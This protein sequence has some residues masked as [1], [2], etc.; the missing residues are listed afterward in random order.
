M[1]SIARYNSAEE[2]N[3]M[4]CFLIGKGKSVAVVNPG[5]YSYALRISPDLR[6]NTQRDYEYRIDTYMNE[7]R[8]VHG[9]N[10]DPREYTGDKMTTLTHQHWVCHCEDHP[11]RPVQADKCF[12]CG[13]KYPD[14]YFGHPEAEILRAYLVK[15]HDQDKNAST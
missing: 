4:A 11:I 10:A 12:R 8:E 13:N 3:R 9:V 5:T 15:K 6:W 14:T 1:L 2:M 7:Y